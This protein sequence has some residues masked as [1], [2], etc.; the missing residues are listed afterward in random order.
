M[1]IKSMETYTLK[2]KINVLSIPHLKEW[3]FRT[4]NCNIQIFKSDRLQSHWQIFYLSFPHDLLP[5]EKKHPEVP[6]K[7]IAK[8]NK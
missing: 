3:A 1:C 4:I 6:G 2:Y 7:S 8:Y 5:Y